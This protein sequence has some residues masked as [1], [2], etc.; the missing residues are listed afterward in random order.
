MTDAEHPPP[1]SPEPPKLRPLNTPL[2]WPG[3]SR[4]LLLAWT[5]LPLL[6]LAFMLSHTASGQPSW[7]SIAE[8]RGMTMLSVVIGSLVLGNVSLITL[9]MVLRGSLGESTWY[10]LLVALFVATPPLAAGYFLGLHINGLVAMMVAGSALCI[11]LLERWVALANI[12]AW[13]VGVLVLTS[14]EQSGQIL[15]TPA[16]AILPVGPSGLHTGWLL[17]P[18]LM[19]VLTGLVALLMLDFV[20]GKERSYSAQLHGSIHQDPLSGLPDFS[21]LEQALHREIDR[22]KRHRVPLCVAVIELDNLESINR[23]LG[24]EVGDAMLQQIASRLEKGLRESDLAAGLG[25]GRFVLLLPHLAADQ[26]TATANRIV[27]MLNDQPIG[28]A[29]SSINVSARVGLASWS[30][31]LKGLELLG[32]AAHALEEAQS[33]RGALAAVYEEPPEL[34]DF[35]GIDISGKH[36]EA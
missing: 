25:D 21:V 35:A 24:Y 22:A 2:G 18:G 14:M 5:A 7:A 15:H 31:G 36:T 17:G 27:S 34:A 13:V 16:L 3:T 29:R 8:P 26:V 4:A 19:S 11:L 30:P 6:V 12:G 9:G 20:A 23:T 33:E 10:Q 32:R 1:L 28:M